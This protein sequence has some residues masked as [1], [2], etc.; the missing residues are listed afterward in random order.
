MIL[1]VGSSEA[2][3]PKFLKV[4]Q[5]PDLALILNHIMMQIRI[6]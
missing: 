4:P 6:A 3:L 1:P 5:D 2:N